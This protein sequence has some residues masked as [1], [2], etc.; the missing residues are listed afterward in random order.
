MIES[1][2]KGKTLKTFLLSRKH[3]VFTEPLDVQAGS[4]VTVFYN[5]SNANLNGKPE[6]WF[7]GSFNCWSHPNGLLSPQRMLPH[8]SRPLVSL[9][10]CLHLK[11]ECTVVFWH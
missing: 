4:S 10:L 9:F 6:H 11:N 7:K 8:M 3:V 5:L 2:N 1:Q